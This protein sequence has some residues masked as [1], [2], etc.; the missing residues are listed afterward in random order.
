MDQKIDED[1]IDDAGTELEGLQSSNKTGK[2][3]S[4]E[5]LGAIKPEFSDG[6][7]AQAVDGAFGKEEEQEPEQPE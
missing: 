4:V 1:E 7:S 6:R 5:K 3:S 2:H